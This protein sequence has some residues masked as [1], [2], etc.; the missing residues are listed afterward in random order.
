MPRHSRAGVTF[1][2]VVSVIAIIA[3]VAAIIFPVFQKVKGGS[4]TSCQSNLKQLGL[5]ITQYQQDADGDFPTGFNATG[6]G[7]AGQLYP[8]TKSTGV[9]HCPDDP[10]EGKFISYA[11]NQ[12]LLKQKYANLPA[13]AATVE[14]YEF[15]TLNCDP[16]TSEAVSAT[17]LSAPQDS[18]R[19]DVGTPQ[20]AYGLNF[21]AVD[22]HVKML[23]PGQVSG[24]PGALRAKT[25]PQGTY[26]KTFA[27]K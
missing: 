4:H 16:S 22:G 11:E 12:N 17:G 8:Y 9:Y 7:W 1:I 10:A 27:I 3:I 18:K 14:L 21:L 6:N 5:A 24:G 15:T 23:T 25:L 19:H 26:V 20:T 13:P 2:E